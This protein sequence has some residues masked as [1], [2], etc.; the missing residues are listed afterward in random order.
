MSL[1]KWNIAKKQQVNK[2]L[3]L[4]PDPNVRYDKNYK[5]EAICNSKFYVKEFVDQ[6]SKLYYLIS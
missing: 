1:R 2:L 6:I 3:E 4:K 5:V